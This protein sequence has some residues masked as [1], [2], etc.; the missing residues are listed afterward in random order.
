MGLRLTMLDKLEFTHLKIMLKNKKITKDFLVYLQF[1][2]H[3][4]PFGSV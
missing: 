4:Q 1:L 3:S 2:P